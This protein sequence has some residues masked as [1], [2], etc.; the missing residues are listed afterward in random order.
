MLYLLD[1]IQKIPG[2]KVFDSKY[3][4]QDWN[5][6]RCLDDSVV[7][8][9]KVKPAGS[10]FASGERLAS[11]TKIAHRSRSLCRP[12]YVTACS[13]LNLAMLEVERVSRTMQIHLKGP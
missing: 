4:S 8:E 1:L 12:T 5:I 11:F 10:V 13:G 6:L 9:G 3:S 7:L 2:K